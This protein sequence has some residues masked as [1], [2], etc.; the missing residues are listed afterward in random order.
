MVYVSPLKALSNDIQKNL[1]QPLAEISDL[2]GRQGILLA[3][4]RTAVR[5]GDTL[6]AERAA[7]DQASAAR[8]G[9]HAGIAVHPAYRRAPAAHVEHRAH[10]S[11]W[12]KSMPWST[13]SAAHIWRSRIARL[14]KLA[15]RRLQRIGLSATVNPI[16]EVAQFLS[17]SAHIVNVGHRR[18]MEL[19]IEV[20]AR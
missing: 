1:E 14:E 9:H 19:A 8:A 4:I 6:T 11:S 5:T 15:G 17:P 18:D 20:P 3:P 12:T 10:R 13:T 7:H 2:A 16:E